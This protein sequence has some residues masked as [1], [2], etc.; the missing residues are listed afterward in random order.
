MLSEQLAALKQYDS[1]T[2][3]NA[4]ALK[5]GLPNLDYTDHTIR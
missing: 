5:L 4:V 2:V 3:F 1:A